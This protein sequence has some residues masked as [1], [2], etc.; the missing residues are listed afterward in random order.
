MTRSQLRH[1]PQYF[2]RSAPNAENWSAVTPRDRE[3]EEAYRSRW[4]H[5]KVVRSTHGVN[6]TGS[7]SWKIYVK[8][9]IVTWETQQTDY[10]TNGPNLPEY[11]PRGCPRGASFSWYMYSP[12]RV[13]Y[14]YVRGE[15]WRLWSE[16]LAANGGDEVRAWASIVEDPVKSVKYKLARGMGGFVRVRHAE[17]FRLISAALIYTIKKFGPDRV[18]G[19]TPIPAM[20]MVS[21]AAGTRFLSLLG[22]VSISFYDWYCDLPPA[23]PQVWGEQTDVPESADWYNS[24]YIVMWGSNVPMTRTP[25]AHFMVEARYRGAKVVAVSP[26]YTDNVK[27]GDLWVHPNPGT[28]GALAMG[29]VHVVLKEFFVDE[30]VDYFTQYVKAY[31]DLPFLVILKSDGDGYVPENFLVAT[32]TGLS[33]ENGEWKPMVWD[34]LSSRPVPPNGSVGHRWG[35]EAGRWNLELSYEGK[36]LRPLLSLLGSED[37]VVPVKLPYF[38]DD[39]AKSVLSRCVPAKRIKGVAGELIVTTVFDLLLAHL[40]VGRGLP[41]DYPQSYDD[42][43]PYTPAWQERVTGVDKS[44][45]VRVARELAENARLTRGR[46]MIIMGSGIN[47]WYHSDQTYRAILSLVILTGCQ[48]VNGGGWAHYVGQEKVRPLEGWTTLA[49]ALDWMRPP[50]QQNGTSFFYFATDQW[51]YEEGTADILLSPLARRFSGLHYADYNVLAVNL[52][53]LPFYP[54]FD[55]NPL[56]LAE[57][58]GTTGRPDPMSVTG[59]VTRMLKDGRINFSV[60]DPDNPVNS[61]KVMFVW[62][63]NILSASGKGHEY[64]LKHMLG[65]TNS[66]MSKQTVRPK[67]V[68]WREQPLTGKLDLLVDVNFRMDGTALYSDV[69]L[70]AATWYEKHDI[71][72]TDLHPF[73]HPFNPAVDPLWESRSDWDTFTGLAKT[74][75][76]LAA[77]HFTGK[78]LDLV[79]VPLLHDTPDEIAQPRGRVSDWFERGEEPIPGK[80]TQRF[81][82]VERDY[83]HVYDMMTSLG[84]L[85]LSQGM[86]AKGVS[87][88]PDREYRELAAELGSVSEGVASGCVKIT[89]ARAA[90]EVILALSGATNG[91]VALKGWEALER[92]CGTV[93]KDL[94][95][96]HAEVRARFADLVNQPRR[97]ITTPAWSGIEK[98]GRQYTAFAV[99]VERKVPWRTFTGRQQF[100][101]DHEL[102][103][104]FGESLPIYRPPVNFEPFLDGELP[105]ASRGKS[106]RA[107]W[108]TPHNKWSIHTTYVDNLRMLT[109]FRG[110]PTVWLNNVDAEAA[111]I[112]DNDWVEVFS[113]NGVMVARAVVSH[114]IPKG[115]A[116]SY[117]AQDRT[118]NVP[119]SSMTRARGGLHNSVT[120][121]RVKPT[122]MAG[123]YGQLSYAFNYWGPVGPQRDTLVLIRKME[124]VDWLED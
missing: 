51:R 115:A 30:Q 17:L 7:C 33:A 14:P 79:T 103:R 23:S 98:G 41:G 101:I 28:D 112:H 10:P 117:H 38:Q 84:P 123:G 49:F 72:S 90:A 46:S 105:P 93:L 85:V 88:I 97:A 54:Q 13:K 55:A 16:A 1:V 22:G 118:V 104:E 36:P 2:R 6:C 71:S 42:P 113:R 39:G 116:L 11:E 52:G 89:D 109:L 87:F 120:R 124:E 32:D 106:I 47:H 99:N 8:D 9:G 48:G 121:I 26:D 44:I 61:P 58:T 60:K 40:G 73:I 108:I 64:F 35:N 114:R 91:S 122:Q 45:A 110:G 3:W 27:F 31:T 100:Y 96:G 25:D 37:A 34:A 29:M 77:K 94:A 43:R 119:A 19:F 66:V 80:T 65:S 69:V 5:D 86:G 107:R 20:S 57:E 4:Q 68:V 18:F 15:L 111:G 70:P 56:R 95:E 59:R 12:L 67:S 75:S 53:W 62:R 63:A 81:A 74:F 76:E 50:R 82:M 24:S 21:Y 92:K 102:Y 78:V 83:A